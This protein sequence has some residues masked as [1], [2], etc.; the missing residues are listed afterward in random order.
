MRAASTAVL[1]LAAVALSAC[2]DPQRGRVRVFWTFAGQ[3][4]QQ[5]GVATIQVDIPGEVLTPNQFV[6][7][8]PDNSANIGA[9]LGFYFFNTYTL[10][11]TGLSA[12]G[13]ATYQGSQTF[14]V[15]GDVDLNIDLQRQPSTFATA[16]V[17]WDALSSTGGFAPGANGAMTCSEAQVDMVRIFVDGTALNDIPCA[18]SG[19]EGAIVEP[20]TAG[21]HSFTI[22]AFR[23]VAGT[24]TLVYQSAAAV[25]QPFQIG[26]TTNVD[27]TAES[28]GSGTGSATLTWG[29]GCVGTVTYTLTP[30]SGTPMATVSNASC[31][32]P[33]P[34][35]SV[36]A[37]L[38]VVDATSGTQHN[39]DRFLGVPNQSTVSKTFNFG[40]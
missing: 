10:T 29:T 34:L 24:L 26:A 11:V 28:L 17:S 40:P 12:D 2:G 23:N 15:N 33:V 21:N 5:A 18:S 19:V 37:G 9:D 39:T 20:L 38:W 8:N 3:N 4:C 16:D 31:T 13:V 32:T 14:T 22:S 35:N 36:T 25:T 6:C 1:V 30:P 27:V 7:T